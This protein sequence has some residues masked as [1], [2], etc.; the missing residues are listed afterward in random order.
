[1][2][3]IFEL[4]TAAHLLQKLHYE[5][6][7]L[8]KDPDNVYVTFNFFVTA[9]HILDWLYPKKANKKK[10]EKERDNSILLQICSHVANGSK[11]FE[12][13][14]PRH[15]SVSDTTHTGGYWPKGYFPTG[16]FPEGYFPESNLIIHLDGDSKNQLGESVSVIKLATMIVDFWDKHPDLKP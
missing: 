10:R 8:K 3:G 14:D 1:M 13:E 5:F 16:Y 7:L 4:S 6:A 2:K 12:V 9:E 15:Q 11:H